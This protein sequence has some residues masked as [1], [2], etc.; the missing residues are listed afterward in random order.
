MLVPAT[1]VTAPVK[2]LSED[3]PEP[4]DPDPCGGHSNEAIGHLQ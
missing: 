2:V 4:P 3:T 1:S